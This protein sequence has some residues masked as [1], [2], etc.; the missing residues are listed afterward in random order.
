[1]ENKKIIIIGAGIAG[2]SAGCYGQMNGYDTEIYELNDTPGGLCTG[3]K[4]KDYVIDGCYEWMIGIN[5]DSIFNKLWMEVGALQNKEIRVHQEFCRCEFGSGKTVIFYSDVDKLRSHLLE[6]APEDARAIH[7]ITTAIKKLASFFGYAMSNSSPKGLAG[8]IITSFKSIPVLKYFRKYGKISIKEYTQKN[9]KNTYLKEA[10]LQIFLT[11]YSMAVFLFNMAY[12]CNKDA[13]LPKGGSLGVV[14]SIAERYINLGGRINYKAPVKSIIIK[15][16]KASGIELKDG[17][18][19]YADLIVSAADG[20]HTIYDLLKGQ[21]LTETIKKCYSGN[22]PTFTSVQVSL[23]VNADLSDEAQWIRV[24]L[25]QSI[26]LAGQELKFISFYNYFDDETMAPK[27]KSIITSHN[28]TP[29]E[30]W[31][32]FDRNS[33]E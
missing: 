31:E 23:G 6:V 16:N 19:V 13:G 28:Y 20:H 8:K 12:Y 5:P 25:D 21:Y 11:D 4:R 27:G 1:M 17:R 3:W 22:Y 24:E 29:Y 26:M 18:K 14:N 9:I 7:E 15:D 30:Y 2:M 33:H 10:L 32:K